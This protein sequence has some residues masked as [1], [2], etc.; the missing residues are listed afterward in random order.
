MGDIT[1]YDIEQGLDFWQDH[2]AGH[3]N[4]PDECP[5]CWEE[6]Y[7]QMKNTNPLSDN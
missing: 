2:L 3:P 4:F 1:D 5:Y 7:E 6:E